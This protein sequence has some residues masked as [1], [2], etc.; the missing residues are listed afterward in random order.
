MK[1]IALWILFMVTLIGTPNGYAET[2]K[3]GDIAELS[4]VQTSG[5]TQTQTILLNNTLKYIPNERVIGLWNINIL[6]GETANVQTADRFFTELRADYKW[7][8]RRYGFGTI[9]T[10]KDTF[11]GLKSRNAVGVGVGYIFIKT[12][13]DTLMGEVG[14]IHTMEKLTTQI[15]RD[16]LAGRL[17]GKFTHAFTEKNMF[18][19]SLEY[20]P[21]FDQQ[22][23]YLVNSETALVAN[24]SGNLSLKTSYLLRYDNEPPA[25]KKRADNTVSAAVV[26]N[27]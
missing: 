17:F 5:N 11:A 16:Y 6:K 25:G 15:D 27:F 8:E 18:L 10:L 21:D 19:Q 13:K 22:N 7:T 3:W 2:K 9:S 4:Y 12:A 23:N 24:L 20:I 26:A 1:K 14:L